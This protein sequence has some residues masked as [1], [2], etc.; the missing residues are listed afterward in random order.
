MGSGQLEVV[1]GSLSTEVQVEGILRWYQLYPQIDLTADRIARVLPARDDEFQRLIFVAAG[2][3]PSRCFEALRRQCGPDQV[4]Q[5]AGDLDKE[6]ASVRTTEIDYAVW[7]RDQR[8]ADEENAQQSPDRFNREDCQT[9]E[10]RLVHG[11]LYF[12]ERGQHLDNVG[13]TACAGSRFRGSDD[14]PGVGGYS[15]D[16]WVPVGIVRHAA[17]VER[18]RLPW[19]ALRVRSVKTK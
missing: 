8:N 4:W 15:A 2:M 18:L 5:I 6:V 1:G 19:T 3:R 10:E 11:G 13:L 14:V 16:G 17:H 7:A 9:L 12:Q